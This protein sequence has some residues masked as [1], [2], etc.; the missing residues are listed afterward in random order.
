MI[1][2]SEALTS[3]SDVLQVS[4]RASLVNS[5]LDI[6][7]S[8]N[9]EFY[10]IESWTDWFKYSQ[11]YIVGILYCLTRMI[12]NISMVYMPFYLQISLYLE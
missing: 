5:A 1:N 2:I 12:V 9:S 10:E 3:R 6:N 7:Q 8:K 4:A 11:F